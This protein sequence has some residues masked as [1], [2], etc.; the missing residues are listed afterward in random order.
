MLKIIHQCDFKMHYDLT[1][2]TRMSV[3]KIRT[4]NITGIAAHPIRLTVILVIMS[5]LSKLLI[6]YMYYLTFLLK[7]VEG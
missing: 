6:V 7:D 4:Y 1:I 3:L 2:K 5:R